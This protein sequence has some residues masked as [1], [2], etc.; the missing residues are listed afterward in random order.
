MRRT[1]RFG[2]GWLPYMYTPEMFADSMTT[3][4]A[5][6]ERDAPVRPGLFIWG[7]VHE[8]GETA[9]TYAIDSLSKTYAQDFTRLV[10]RYAFAGTPDDVTARLREFGAAGVET[11]IVSFACPRDQMD[12]VRALFAAEVLP[13]LKGR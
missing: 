10:G 9:R 3:I 6:R 5:Q 12:A 2:D 11:I 8:D 4:D 13:A 7:C 1:A